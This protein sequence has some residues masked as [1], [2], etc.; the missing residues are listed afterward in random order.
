MIKCIRDSAIRIPVNEETKQLAWFR[1]VQ[2]FLIRK[3]IPFGAKSDDEV[4]FKKYYD[5]DVETKYLM[6]PRFYPLRAPG[7][8]VVD[9]MSDGK[10]VRFASKIIPRNTLQKDAI[11]WM[12]TNKKGILCLQPGE[13][14]TVVAIESI[15]R[16]GKKTIVYVHKDA[17]VKQ[18]YER[19]MEH[20][21]IRPSR[22]SK[23]KS[24][25]YEHQLLNSDVIITTS[26][27]MCS[28]LKNKKNV[29]RILRQADFGIAI[30][31]ECHTCAGAEQYS[32]SS[33]HTPAAR[34]YGLSATP[35][36]ADGNTD[37][38]ELNLGKI[39]IPDNDESSTMIPKI[40]Q[41]K[42]SHG[43]IDPHYN[44]LYR[45][46]AWDRQQ[47]NKA[48]QL[49]RDRYLKMI[50][51][52]KNSRYLKVMRK[53][54][55]NIVDSER[56]MILLSDR[57]NILDEISKICPNKNE[58]GFFIPR[59]KKDRDEHLTRRLVFSTFGSC[60]D[61]VDKPEVDCLVL[62]N[63][64]GNWQQAIGR[65]IRS[66][67]GKKQPVIIDV[68]DSDCQ[69]HVKRGERRKDSYEEKGWIVE[70]RIIKF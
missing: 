49:D 56:T 28:L 17:L 63:P 13:G 7:V 41:L 5:V 21:E 38:M 22:I 33:L 65:A 16:I 29:K 3:E 10:D 24:N 26:Q 50:V 18:W 69:D 23:L 68:I 27:L 36:R 51:S 31:D 32:R 61:G 35:G 45:N 4:V 14:K 6:I 34:V 20:T 30:W 60:R 44:H 12:T 58:V 42:F 2:T 48:G 40:V 11:N 46:T 59:S 66:K 57:I 67:N 39:Y 70:E 19:F 64:T 52:S 9:R 1:Q 54:V 25:N 62:A 47:G 8:K 55:K 43:I 53:V 37:I 15:S